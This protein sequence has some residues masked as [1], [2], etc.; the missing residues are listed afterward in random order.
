MTFS[1]LHY[2]IMLTKSSTQ[3]RPQ[4]IDFSREMLH[5]LDHMVSDSE[6]PFNGVIWLLVCRPFTPFLALFGEL[7]GSETEDA[8]ERSL[9]LA[10]MERLPVFLKKMAARNSLAA[11]LERVAVTFVQ[12]A[13]S[14]VRPTSK[15]VFDHTPDVE[16]ADNSGSS[17]GC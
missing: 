4:C 8:Q 11:K 9:S 12:H 6:E 1:Y 5:L 14:L 17:P 2:Q 7:L 13:R 3:M 10:A 15:L 16:N